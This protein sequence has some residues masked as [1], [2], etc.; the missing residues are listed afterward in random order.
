MDW[1]QIVKDVY[2]IILQAGPVLIAAALFFS[3]GSNAG[4]RGFGRWGSYMKR[5]RRTRT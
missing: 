1:L 3:P 5:S 4:I 2:G